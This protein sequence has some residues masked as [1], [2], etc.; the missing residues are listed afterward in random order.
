VP[1][2]RDRRLLTLALVAALLTAGLLGTVDA[3]SHVGNEHLTTGHTEFADASTSFNSCFAGLAGLLMQRV[4]WFNGQTLFTRADSGGDKHVYVAEHL[5]DRDGDGFNESTGFRANVDPSQ[6]RLYRTNNTYTFTD[7][8]DKQRDV[9]DPKTWVVKEY[10]D[11]RDRKDVNAEVTKGDTGPDEETYEKDKFYVFVV[12]TGDARTD[13][14]LQKDYNFAMV[15]DTCRFYGAQAGEADHNGTSGTSGDPWGQ[16]E[17]QD[18]NHTHGVF[19]I[20]LWT[21]GEPNTPAGGNAQVPDDRDNKGN[22]SVDDDPK[23]GQP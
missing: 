8:N 10:F 20:D 1:E 23:D 16:H 2:A 13:G 4:T 6:E 7:P 14:T 22:Q 18:G 9:E 11:L 19:S 12:Q 17:E 21:G 3:T 5:Q 15:I